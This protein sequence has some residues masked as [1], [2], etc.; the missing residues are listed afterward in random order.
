MIRLAPIL[1]I[2][3]LASCAQA[4]IDVSGIVAEVCETWPAI[5]YDSARDSPETVEQVREANAR[6]ATFCEGA[7]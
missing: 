1:L 6:R 7:E 4:A 2:A 5:T 3:A